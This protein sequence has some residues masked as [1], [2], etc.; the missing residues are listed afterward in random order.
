MRVQKPHLLRNHVRFALQPVRTG[1][2]PRKPTGGTSFEFIVRRETKKE[3]E[4]ES[5]R[6]SESE[7]EEGATI[8]NSRRVSSALDGESL[9]AGRATPFRSVKL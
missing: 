8:N 3:K 6:E 7:R 5:E 4:K 2:F 1:W 9:L